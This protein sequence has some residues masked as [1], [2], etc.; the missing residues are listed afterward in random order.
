MEDRGKR[1]QLKVWGII[2][3]YFFSFPGK[4][5]K[6]LF[7]FVVLCLL[8]LNDW[9]DRD[10]ITGFTLWSLDDRPLGCNFI[11]GQREPKRCS[12]QLKSYLTKVSLSTFQLLSITL[13]SICFSYFIFS[14]VHL[15]YLAY[16]VFYLFIMLF[17]VFSTRIQ[18]PWR[19]LVYFDYC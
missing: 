11:L 4:S 13:S 12:M 19:V 15:N 7:W 3:F 14:P 10:S 6:T 8:T 16:N 2:F 1:S 5:V 9:N 17:S 18:T